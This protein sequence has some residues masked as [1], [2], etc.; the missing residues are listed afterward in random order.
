[1][2]R[3]KICG[4][5]DAAFAVEA[6]RRGADVIDVNSAIESVPGVK[7]PTLLAELLAA[8]KSVQALD[9][10]GPATPR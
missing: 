5:T 8:W 6:A 4:I 9:R 2:P 10:R 3:L 1:M 7:S